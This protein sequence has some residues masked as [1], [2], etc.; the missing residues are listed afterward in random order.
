MDAVK[1][2][3]LKSV[4]ITEENTHGQDILAVACMHGRANVAMYLIGQGRG[5]FLDRDDFGFTAIDYAARWAASGGG[6]PAMKE[7]E[8]ALIARRVI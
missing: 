7:V 3:D 2:L 1:F 8:K 5:L 6:D 4:G